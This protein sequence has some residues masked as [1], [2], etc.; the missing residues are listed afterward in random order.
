MSEISIA[1]IPEGLP[2]SGDRLRLF[3]K[4]LSM[5]D[6][7]TFCEFFFFTDRSDEEVKYH[8][9]S[10]GCPRKKVTV[11][12]IVI[13]RVWLVESLIILISSL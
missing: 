9:G 3:V 5:L 11:S 10:P 13:S 2:S 12:G 7:S 6:G 8:D 1:R 4:T